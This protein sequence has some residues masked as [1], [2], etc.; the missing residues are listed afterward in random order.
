MAAIQHR[1]ADR[2][3]GAAAAPPERARI[4]ALPGLAA[5]ARDLRLGRSAAGADRDADPRAHG[6]APAAAGRARVMA[7][8]PG[9]DFATNGGASSVM[10]TAPAANGRPRNGPVRRSAPPEPLPRVLALDDPRWSSF[11]AE[12]THAT[13]FHHPAWAELLAATYGYRAFAV[14][15]T[16]EAGAIVAGTPFV[17]IRIPARR[18]W[19]SLPFTDECPPL[20]VDAGARAQYAAA[21]ALAQIH[22]RAPAVHVRG[23]LDGV[24]WRSSADAVIHELELD[25]DADRVRARFSRSQVIRNIARA[26][27][28]GVT[29]R[30][31][32]E[33]RD[34]DAFYALHV[35][36]RRRQ[37]VPVQPRRFFELLWARLV[38]PGMASILLA[39]AGRRKAVAGALFLTSG[40]CTIYKFGASDVDC[41]P[42]RP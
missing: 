4:C 32:T 3:E 5:R 12:R 23:L 25:R 40:G 36:T 39:D 38:E 9:T 27:R 42:L 11:V 13:A 17:E 37:G 16:D 20:A 10:T 41:W 29:V 22:L 8:E 15:V 35:R 6:G 19:V 1:H 14:V 34:L 2:V 26:E 21:L 28:E 30:R 33:P 24:G 31:A 7:V 18:R